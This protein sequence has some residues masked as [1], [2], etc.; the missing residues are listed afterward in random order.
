MTARR[1]IVVEMLANE[2]IQVIRKL[3]LVPRK[4][5]WRRGL[6]TVG[7]AAD[8]KFCDLE[9]TGAFSVEAE[10]IPAEVMSAIISRTV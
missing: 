3:G 10:V 9:N 4:S 6:R 5:T 8:A 2:D 1:L 7:R